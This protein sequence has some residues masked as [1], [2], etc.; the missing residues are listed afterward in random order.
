M[1][2]K[3]S[4]DYPTVYTLDAYC[5][6]LLLHPRTPA[7]P[8]M[9]DS[10]RWPCFLNTTLPLLW[11]SIP[12]DQNK[13]LEKSEGNFHRINARLREQQASTQEGSAAKIFERLQ[14]D[15]KGLRFQVGEGTGGAEDVK[16]L[17]FR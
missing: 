15:V 8:V 12:Q 16:G 11:C 10:S 7:L 3:R 13:K 4:D 5:R 6:C 14:E 17:R 2:R 9:I 1:S